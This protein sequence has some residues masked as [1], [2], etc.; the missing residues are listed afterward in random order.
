MRRR[1]F[2]TGVAAFLGAGTVGSV[3]FSTA[4]VE[5]DVT[6]SVVN[7]DSGDAAIGLNPGTVGIS[8]VNGDGELVLDTSDEDYGGLNPNASFTYGDDADP[9]N[10]GHVFSVTNND[11]ESRDVTVSYADSANTAVSF[12]FGDGST[13]DGSTDQTFG[14]SSGDTVYAAM[15]VDTKAD[16]VTDGTLTFSV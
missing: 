7:D 11:G 10:N 8:S 15:T 3:A 4:T 1:G 5:R 13:V 2:V 6:V 9:K 12:T 14:L 16:S